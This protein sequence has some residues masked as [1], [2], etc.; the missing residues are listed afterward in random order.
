M[1]S[2]Y[3][4]TIFPVAAAVLFGNLTFSTVNRK[5]CVDESCAFRVHDENGRAEGNPHESTQ[6]QIQTRIK[7]T[8][9]TC[10]NRALTLS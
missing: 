5:S 10:E 8:Q 7:L 3:Y 1:E 2:P 4:S 6:I 9:S